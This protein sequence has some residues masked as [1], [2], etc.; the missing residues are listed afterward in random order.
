MG[1]SSP[2]RKLGVASWVSIEPPGP[3]WR[4]S[5]LIGLPPL[6]PLRTN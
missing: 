3:E 5:A 4:L 1:V 2:T 6:P